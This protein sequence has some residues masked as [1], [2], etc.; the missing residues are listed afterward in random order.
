MNVQECIEY[1]EAHLEVRYATGNIMYRN[2]RI[3]TP[4]GCVNHSCGCA[5]PS[6]D[7]WYNL[8]NRATTW[9]VNAFLGDF[10]KGEG[11]ILLMLPLNTRPGGCGGG[12]KG[13][14]NNSRIQWEVAEPA[15]H[16]YS[17]GTMINYDVKKN[18]EYFNRMWKMLVCWNVYCA[19]KYKYSVANIADH[20]E[21]HRAGYGS[22]HS[23]MSQWL[24]K[25]GKSMDMLRAEVAKIISSSSNVASSVS[26]AVQYNATGM[27]N[28]SS[29]NIR[30]GPSTA[31]NICG[32]LSS[33]AT[34]T[35][36]QKT[37]DG[38]WYKIQNGWV[39]AKY[40]NIASTATNTHI[41]N[42]AEDI[43]VAPAKPANML[44]TVNAKSLNVRKGPSITY[45]KIDRVVKGTKV[46]VIGK[47]KNGDWYLIEVEN[48][49]S[50]WVSGKYISVILSTP[51]TPTKPIVKPSTPPIV[52]NKDNTP[53]SWAKEAID[54]AIAN[55]ILSGDSNGNY[56]LHS[57]C[58]RQ[59]VLIFIYRLYK[60]IK[61]I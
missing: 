6:L 59:E 26:K 14:W 55:K 56:K 53:E 34:V 58:T 39:Y 19:V 45:A 28:A 57:T 36:T 49:I 37:A 33:G 61:G 31:Y 24:P 25:H 21:A 18:T 51:S 54:W 43:I 4:V 8:M 27:V 3:I 52:T 42:A 12:P 15:G 2:R 13:S 9:G 5:Q 29:L 44:G 47:N 22:N 30:S 7:V 17:G 16:T 1:V 20:S 48:G 32:S 23:D 50:G 46:S 10:H 40:V 41:V 60:H 11:K 35:I 38:L